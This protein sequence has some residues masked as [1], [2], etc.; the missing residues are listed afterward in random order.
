MKVLVTGAGAVLGQGV[1][2]SLRASTL[3]PEIVAVD[4]SPFAVGLYWAD[5]AHLVPK[6]SGVRDMQA[7]RALLDAERPDAV[8]VG[9]DVELLA[10]AAH[11]AELEA[12]F[13]CSVVVSPPSVV[14]IAD[15]KYETFRFLRDHGFAHPGSC[16]PHEAEV[17]AAE[18][19]FPLI[20]KPRVGARSIGVHKVHD[21]HALRAAITDVPDAV[22]Q[23]LA[24][25]DDAEYTAGVVVFDGRAEASI[26]MRRDLRDGNTHRAYVDC[27][28]ELNKEVRLIAEAL[29]ADGPVNFQFRLDADAV[30]VF[31]INA[32]FSGTTPFRMLAGFNEVEMVLRRAVL[33]EPIVQP[34]VEP[35]TILRYFVEQV[36]RPGELIT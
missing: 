7:I 22:V 24:G 8:L 10:F 4:F 11:R 5:A 16:L 31:E 25:P 2:R 6:S 30:K 15:D 23:T 33:G 34:V 12:E 13:G 9:T 26:V 29:G 32:R 19:G 27:Y 17:F 36:V 1:I 14:R 28:P 20:V 21:L 18:H 35:M 3:N